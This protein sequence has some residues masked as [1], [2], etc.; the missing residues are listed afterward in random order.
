MK[1]SYRDLPSCDEVHPWVGLLGEYWRCLQCGHVELYR[2]PLPIF[3][4]VNQ[5]R[6]QP[7][8]PSAGAGGGGG[9]SQTGSL[10]IRQTASNFSGSRVSLR[11]KK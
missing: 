1:K 3:A 10:D 11:S 5:T 2:N 8:E 4:K 9:T 6:M 7:P